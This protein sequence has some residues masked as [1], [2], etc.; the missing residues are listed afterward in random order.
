MTYECHWD[1]MEARKE[2]PVKIEF[3]YCDRGFYCPS[4]LH[5]VANKNHRCK[6]CGQKLLDMFGWDDT[7]V[8]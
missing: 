5:G 3:S 6:H 1:E 8:I 7:E 2:I 4:C